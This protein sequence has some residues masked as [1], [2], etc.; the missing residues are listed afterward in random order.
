MPAQIGKGVSVLFKG[1]N[2]L[3]GDLDLSWQLAHDIFS[4]LGVVL[5]V[6]KEEMIN[7]STAVSG[8][9][10]AFFCY[11]IKEKKNA[12]SKRNEFIE[13]LTGAAV[14]LGFDRRE[15]ELLSEKTV[16]GIIAMLI[17]RNLTCVDIIKMVASKGGT[18]QAGL[19]VL[20]AGGSVDEAVKIA[21][22]RADE[23]GRES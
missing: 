22:K 3:E 11:Y 20:E 5:V 16:D 14:S 6:D 12:V 1:Q 8:S 21:L 18:T 2:A 7:A 10:P 15:A 13:M 9:G 23:L 19:G 4:N 17:E